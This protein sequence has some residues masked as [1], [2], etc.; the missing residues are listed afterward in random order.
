LS[1][2]RLSDENVARLN[3]KRL[4]EMVRDPASV[5]VKQ[6]AIPEDTHLLRTPGAFRQQIHGQFLDTECKGEKAPWAKTHGLLQFREH[7]ASCWYGYN[8]SYKSVFLNELFTYW[9][10]QG[11][12]VG[13]A[14]F[15]MPAFKVGALAVKQALALEMPNQADIDRAI[16]RLSE[17][18]VIYDVL[19]KV[20]PAH[21]LAVIR[22]CAIELGV[23]QFLVDNLTTLLPVGN[24]A[25]DLHQQFTAGCLTIART[26]GIHIHLVGHVPKPEKGDVSQIPGG[27]G[28]R[29]TG[30]VSDMLEN[31]L[32]VWRN[33]PKED[34]LDDPDLPSGE[35]DQLRK[36]PD[37]VVA[38]RK[39]KFWDFRGALKFWINRRL[40]RFKEGGFTECQPFL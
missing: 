30:A 21:L 38:V 25:H 6:W 36:E 34:K 5:P 37:L 40:L 1:D 4:I 12:V 3:L 19:G 22:Y 39:Q 24:D 35:R 33:L 27:Y 7:E 10:C 20:T 2:N 17:S 32:A 26:T 31:M 15:E 23:R 9:A 18:M 13:M 14:S 11:I 29:G 16:D 8:G 28:L